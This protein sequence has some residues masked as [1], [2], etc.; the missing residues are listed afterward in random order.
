MSTDGGT[1]NMIGVVLYR[2]K[3]S[4]SYDSLFVLH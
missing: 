4:R 1:T 2:N 3:R